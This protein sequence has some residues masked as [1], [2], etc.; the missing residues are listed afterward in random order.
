[1]NIDAVEQQAGDFSDV[2]LNHWRSTH[3]LA[4]FVI[5]VTAGP[6]LRCLSAMPRFELL[7]PSQL[8]THEKS[9]L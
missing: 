4:G 8:I 3:A 7:D 6:A 1:M 9:K 5:E 2:A